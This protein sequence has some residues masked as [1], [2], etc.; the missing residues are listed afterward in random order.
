MEV[1]KKIKD[2]IKDMDTL[3]AF[4][5]LVEIMGYSEKEAADILNV[6]IFSDLKFKPHGVVPN[7]KQAYIKFGDKW[8][9]IVGGGSGLY[10]DGVTT[11]EVW[12]S[13]IEDPIGYVSSKDV[14]QEI[15]KLQ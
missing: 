4:N 1:P 10:G 12:T 9:S 8:I 6:V 2:Y 15:L 13:E 14:T 5:T 7:A 3:E 11:F